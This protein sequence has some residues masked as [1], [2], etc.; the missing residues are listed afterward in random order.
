MHNQA[1]QH[2]VS[3]VCLFL[4]NNDIN[5]STAISLLKEFCCFVPPLCSWQDSYF[6]IRTVVEQA[7]MG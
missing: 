4:Y 6:G 7:A 5:F 1:A 2:E 3:T